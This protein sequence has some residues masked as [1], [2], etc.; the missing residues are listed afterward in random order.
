MGQ[1]E[2]KG[3]W[4][5]L[6]QKLGISG[7][8]LHT[9]AAHSW[10]VGRR[11]CELGR[12]GAGV[13]EKMDAYFLKQKMVAGVSRLARTACCMHIYFTYWKSSAFPLITQMLALW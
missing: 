11:K 2:L 13:K 12:C 8:T 5:F 10:N 7:F 9:G 3:L 4:G 6:A 1:S